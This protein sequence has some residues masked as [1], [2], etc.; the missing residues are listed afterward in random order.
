[1][2]YFSVNS[3]HFGPK[4]LT[5]IPYMHERKIYLNK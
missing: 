2:V 4:K 5:V 3:R 1:M